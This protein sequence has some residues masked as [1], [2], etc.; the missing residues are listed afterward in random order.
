MVA[1]KAGN[2]A[3]QGDEA[4]GAIGLPDH[5]FV[6]RFALGLVAV[7]QLRIPPVPQN[8][9]QFPG[10]VERV[11]NPHVHALAADRAMDM[12]S[13]AEQKHPALA[14]TRSLSP[15]D[16]EH[17][18]P[19]R[20]A[21]PERV[22]TALVNQCLALR[23]ARLVMPVRRRVDDDEL[24]AILRQRKNASAPLRCSQTCASAWSRSPATFTSARTKCSG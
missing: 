19:S 14:T 22:E 18:R 4:G 11:L 12:R 16:A 21:E 6:D 2:R 10:E 24:P 9:A 3:V 8:Q 13:V 17:R 15:V 7:E 5:R 1:D 23:K 20:I